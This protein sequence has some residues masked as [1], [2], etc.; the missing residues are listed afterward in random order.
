MI[1]LMK[2]SNNVF[3]VISGRYNLNID[4]TESDMFK[5]SKIKFNDLVNRVRRKGFDEQTITL[6]QFVEWMMNNDMYKKLYI[7]YI[8]NNKNRSLAPSVDRLDDYK[9]YSIDNIRLCTWKEN[10]DKY[11]SDRLIGKNTKQS[12]PVIAISFDG[13]IKR[14]HSSHYAAQVTGIIRSSI[15]RSCRT[16]SKLEIPKSRSGEYIWLFESDYTY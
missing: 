14:F 8:N 10:K 6:K 16:N 1:S 13:T 4:S 11:N 3:K 2:D 5:R 9:T 15:N 12:K 7:D